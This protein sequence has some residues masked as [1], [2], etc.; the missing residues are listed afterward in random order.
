MTAPHPVYEPFTSLVNGVFSQ[1]RNTSKQDRFTS[2]LVRPPVL[3]VTN[4]E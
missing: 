4:D 1:R 2:R 3:E